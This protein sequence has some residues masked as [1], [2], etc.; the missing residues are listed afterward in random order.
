MAL[1]DIV[2]TE[3]VRTPVED[4]LLREMVDED[5]EFI[6]DDST[7]LDDILGSGT[8]ADL[9]GDDDDLDDG[10]IDLNDAD[11]EGMLDDYDYGEIY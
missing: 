7:E 4:L 1:V 5:T 8:E 6:T 3:T 11:L 2:A 10:D 9:F